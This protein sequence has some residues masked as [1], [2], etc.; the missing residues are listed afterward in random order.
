MGS[1]HLRQEAEGLRIVALR[2]R[3]YSDHLDARRPPAHVAGGFTSLDTL[4][5]TVCVVNVTP[6]K[7]GNILFNGGELDT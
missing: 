7:N 2:Q 5:H 4:S 6:Y 1:F 3:R